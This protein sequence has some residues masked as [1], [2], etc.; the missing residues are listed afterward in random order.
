MIVTILPRGGPDW[1]HN[2]L[3]IWEVLL[4]ATTDGKVKILDFGLAKAFDTGSS[5]NTGSSQLSHS[6]TGFGPL[7]DRIRSRAG[8]NQPG[9]QH[10]SSAR[11]LRQIGESLTDTLKRPLRDLR[12]S[13]TDRSIR[14]PYP[15]RACARKTPCE[16]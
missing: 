11:G 6:P 16:G 8:G 15:A 13:V 7:G 3:M 9:R 14:S 4:P 1:V 5:T 2:G 10:M 12:I